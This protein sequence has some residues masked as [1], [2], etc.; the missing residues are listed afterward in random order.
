MDYTHPHPANT[1]MA[2]IDKHACFFLHVT[3]R[4]PKHKLALTD[5]PTQ[6]KQ[7]EQ[8]ATQI[9]CNSSF[10]MTSESDV[11]QSF[12]F[13]QIMS[14]NKLYQLG[15]TGVQ[16]TQQD[17]SCASFARPCIILFFDIKYSSS[18]LES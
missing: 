3:H 6:T 11:M 13:E 1:A 16:S 12:S 17:H 14:F 4:N 18:C 2:S 9:I 7:N 5:S 15:I 10:C 8:S